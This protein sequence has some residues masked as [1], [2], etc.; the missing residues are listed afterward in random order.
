MAQSTQLNGLRSCTAQYSL[1]E[2]PSMIFSFTVHSLPSF[3]R[4][5]TTGANPCD[6]KLFIVFHLSSAFIFFV[7]RCV[8]PVAQ[9]MEAGKERRPDGKNHR[10]HPKEL[11]DITDDRLGSQMGVIADL[12]KGHVGEIHPGGAADLVFA[13]HMV[14]V[15]IRLIADPLMGQL[16]EIL[17][18]AEGH[19]FLGT[20]LDTG[21]R[22]A[23]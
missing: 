12:V 21:R 18:L 3:L 6:F 20:R 17:T 11:L 14:H 15:S 19:D 9:Q 5:E 10:H 8:L 16:E 4:S 7:F 22:P 13:I 1:G 2:S 23:E